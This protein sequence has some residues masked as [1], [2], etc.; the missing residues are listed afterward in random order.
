MRRRRTKRGELNAPLQGQQ[1]EKKRV[2]A[3]RE[4]A[5]VRGGGAGPSPTVGVTEMAETKNEDWRDEL[6]STKSHVVR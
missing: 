1:Q 6:A 2:F 5:G 3:R 4:E